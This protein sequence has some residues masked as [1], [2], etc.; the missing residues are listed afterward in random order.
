MIEPTESE[1]KESIDEFLDSMISIA[2]EIR[3]TPE[4][5]TNAPVK[6]KVR[7]MDEATAARKP[8][9]RWR[10]EEGGENG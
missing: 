1:S 7:R 2:E 5:V 8:V 3:E 4:H 6:T 9:L 10:P